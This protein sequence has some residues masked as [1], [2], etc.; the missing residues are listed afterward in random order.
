MS[1]SQ[2]TFLK[3]SS[4]SLMGLMFVLLWTHTCIFHNIWHIFRAVLPNLQWASPRFC[5]SS[6]MSSVSWLH[7][8]PT[9][10]IQALCNG[11]PFSW[12]GTG[13]SHQLLEDGGCCHHSQSCS[14]WLCDDIT[15]IYAMLCS[16][17]LGSGPLLRPASACFSDVLLGD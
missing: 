14:A 1:I 5:F 9:H 11:C 6:G 13:M 10:P 7:R 16:S 8:T 12:W 2:L 17:V 3:V 15:N 4:I